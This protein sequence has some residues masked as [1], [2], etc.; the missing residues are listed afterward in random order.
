[1][2]AGM[3]AVARLGNQHAGFGAAIRNKARKKG[4]SSGGNMQSFWLWAE[5]VS[6]LP[7]DARVSVIGR[8][9][10]RSSCVAQSDQ[11][12]YVLLRDHLRR[13]AMR[14]LI[15]SRVS[16]TVAMSISGHKTASMFSRYNITDDRDQREALLKRQQYLKTVKE[17]VMTMPANTR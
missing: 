1:V 7:A 16:Q 5:R 9:Q 13:S 10:S 6:Q 14:D 3:S 2:T 11:I 4:G 15:R 17:K 8:L 12:I